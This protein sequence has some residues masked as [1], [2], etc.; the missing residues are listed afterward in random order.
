M[1]KIK[2]F[3]PVMLVVMLVMAVS[4]PAAAQFRIGPRVGVA[5]N[6]LHFNKDILDGENRA[7]FT[8]GLQ[9]ELMFGHIGFDAS[10]MY[11]RRDAKFME[12]NKYTSV[13]RDYIDIPINFKLKF[14]LPLVSSIVKP[15]LYTGPAFAFLTS[16]TGINEFVRSKKY[17]YSWN[18]GFGVEFINHLQIGAGY[19]LG[20]T[21]TSTPDAEPENK[22][23][24]GKNRYWTVTAAWLF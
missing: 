4:M 23:I 20:L 17:D 1:N 19:G 9:A 3:S 15:Y 24:Q 10:V 7:G 11:V 2:K 6:K 13:S 12:E 21:K 8:G 14:G 16:G 5:V 18:F 22:D